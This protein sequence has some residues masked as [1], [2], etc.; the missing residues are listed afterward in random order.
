MSDIPV[1]IVYVCIILYCYICQKK[2]LFL[3]CYTIGILLCTLEGILNS[4]CISIYKYIV[5]NPRI[6]D[7]N[8]LLHILV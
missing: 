3:Y 7:K 8:I 1:F 2:S 4:R 5:I 6:D